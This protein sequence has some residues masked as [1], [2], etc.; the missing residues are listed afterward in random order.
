MKNKLDWVENAKQRLQQWTDVQQQL[1]VLN[2]RSRMTVVEPSSS[3]PTPPVLD[4]FSTH[5]ALLMWEFPTRQRKQRSFWSQ[6]V[7]HWESSSSSSLLQKP[8]LEILKNEPCETGNDHDD[9]DESDCMKD[10]LLQLTSRQECSP[11]LD[12]SEHFADPHRPLVTDIGCDMFVSRLWSASLAV[13]KDDSYSLL[14]LSESKS[15]QPARF[16]D[17]NLLGVDL[18]RIAMEYVRISSRWNMSLVQLFVGIGRIGWPMSFGAR[19]RLPLPEAYARYWFNFE[20][21]IV[22]VDQTTTTMR[23][24]EREIYNYQDRSPTA[25]W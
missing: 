2:R 19:C 23:I 3:L 16:A 15:Q 6:V 20:Q 9:D 22:S 8:L 24:I 7:Q 5:S 25:S 13:K 4:L 18:Y 1:D 11:C 21:R 10:L 12:W 14:S 17:G